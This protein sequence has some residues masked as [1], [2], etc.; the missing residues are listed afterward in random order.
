MPNPALTNFLPSNHTY[1]VD[2]RKK[3]AAPF[4][5]LDFIW[6]FIWVFIWVL[7]VENSLHLLELRLQLLNIVETIACLYQSRMIQAIVCMW[8][9]H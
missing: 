9:T 4:P 7:L 3:A 2:V 1:A 6:D 5:F 8:G